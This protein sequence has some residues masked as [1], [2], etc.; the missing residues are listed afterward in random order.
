M[1]SLNN[2][3][4]VNALLQYGLQ[5]GKN[6]KEKKVP[7]VKIS[8]DTFTLYLNGKA[9]AIKILLKTPFIVYSRFVNEGKFGIH[10]LEQ[11]IRILFSGDIQS[12]KSAFNLINEAINLEF[13]T[14]CVAEEYTRKNKISKN[15]S[16]NQLRLTKKQT[17]NDE[18]LKESF[19]DN[20]TKTPPRKSN[21]SNFLSLTPLRPIYDSK[22]GITNLYEENLKYTETPKVSPPIKRY[23]DRSST[24]RKNKYMSEILDGSMDLEKK[25]KIFEY[26]PKHCLHKKNLI[27]I[28]IKLN[29]QQIKAVDM[30]RSGKN[31]FVTG[32]AGVGKSFLLQYIVS[33]QDKENIALT[34]STGLAASLI[35]GTTIHNFA[36][37]KLNT[38]Y[39]NYGDYNYFKN[40][41]KK[42]IKDLDVLKRWN[43]IRILFIDEISMIDAYTFDIIDAIAK[44]CRECSKP[45][46]GVQVVLFGDFL[47]L[48]PVRPNKCLN[49]NPVSS[50]IDPLY[51]FESLNWKRTI[52]NVIEL[53]EVYR[54]KRTENSDFVEVLNEIRFGIISEKGKILL[55]QRIIMGGKL[56]SNTSSFDLEYDILSSNNCDACILMPLRRD[57]DSINEEKLSQ[58][59]GE[60]V[61][62]KAK[63]K[64]YTSNEKLFT[65]IISITSNE[66]SRLTCSAEKLILKKGA[67]VMLIKTIDIS[68]QLVNGLRGT[69]ES[70]DS[71]LKY[72]RIRFANGIVKT[73]TPTKFTISN[74]NKI[75]ATRIQLP[76]TLAWAI[77]IHKSQG[78]SLDYVQVSL[79]KTFEEGQ[80]YVALSRAK[81]IDGLT[82][83]GITSADDIC[84][85]LKVSKKCLEYYKYITKINQ[86][87]I[88]KQED[89]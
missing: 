21:L 34:A 54:Q 17:F 6:K 82:I 27:N 25:N 7:N 65:G 68:N 13:K 29:N 20:K 78:L 73:I 35:N 75:L 8:V 79:N 60:P 24:R 52:D 61:E 43:K 84:N 37:I 38:S 69:I 71:L 36:G 51:A 15:I 31:I 70:F 66:I 44:G 46:G 57:V 16:R 11:D 40:I 33:L 23:N 80:T 39:E 32:G 4:N 85:Y 9:E 49:K 14:N 74:F 76:L 89:K 59:A 77:S 42:A 5:K 53:T 12:I 81:S 2:L 47:Q 1:R 56:K 64:I 30:V 19:A 45:F 10:F 22:F 67:R 26:A 55:A 41:I 87:K 50:E 3:G 86:S 88:Y 28:N 18:N 72:P 63:D 48:P 58:L 62:F 83:S